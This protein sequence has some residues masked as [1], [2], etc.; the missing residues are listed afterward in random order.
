MVPALNR[1]IRLGGGL[2]C[3]LLVQLKGKSQETGNFIQN[4]S[5]TQIRAD[6]ANSATQN[7]GMVQADNGN[8]YIANYGD[9]LIFDGTWWKSAKHTKNLFTRALSKDREGKIYVAAQKDLGVL[10]VDSLGREEFVSLSPY[11]PSHIFEN[12]TCFDVIS[13]DGSIAYLLLNH[14]LV[15]NP[16]KKEMEVFESPAEIQTGLEQEGKLLLWLKGKGLFQLLDE[17][18]SPIHSLSSALPPS[19]LVKTILPI[20][21]GKFLL[22]S[23]DH[24]IFTYEAGEISAFG[25]GLLNSFPGLTIYHGTQL[26]DENIALATHEQGVLV[27]NPKGELLQQIDYRGG[28]QINTVIQVFQDQSGSIWAA[29]ESGVSRIRYPISLRA[30]GKE[31]GLEGIIFSVAKERE[32]LIA[33]TTTGLYIAQKN[34]PWETHLQFRKLPTIREAWDVLSYDG[35]IFIA[36]ATGI[37]ELTLPSTLRRISQNKIFR[38]LHPSSLHPDYIYVGSKTGLS[39]LKKEGSKWIYLPE[40]RELGHPINTLAESASGKLWAAGTKDAFRFSFGNNFPQI[41]EVLSLSPAMGKPNLQ[42][43]ELSEGKGNVLFGTDK[44]IYEFNDSNGEFLLKTSEYAHS[45]PDSAEIYGIYYSPQ[46]KLWFS[47]TPNLN[48]WI[49]MGADLPGEYVHL[50]YT[51]VKQYAWCFFTD[52]TKFTWIGTENGL[53]KVGSSMGQVPPFKFPTQIRA[54]KINEDSLLFGGDHPPNSSLDYSKGQKTYL[55]KLSSHIQEINFSFS[56][57]EY[58]SPEAL[59]YTY[60]LKGF[61]KSWS[62]WRKVSTK[63]YTGLWEGNYTFSVKARNSYGH[64]SE[65][66]SYSFRILPPWY[67]S[68]WAY[69]IYVALFLGFLALLIRAVTR[70]QQRKIL[71]QEQ[72]LK[73]ERETAERLRAVDRLKD[74]FLANTSHELRTPLNGIIGL[75][76]GLKEG[77]DREI[78]KEDEESLSLIISSGKRLASLV[79]DILDLSKMRNQDLQLTQKALDIYTLVDVV[80]RLNQPLTKGKAVALHNQVQQDLPPILA[81]ENR[82]QQVLQNLVDNAVKFTDRGTVEVTAHITDEPGFM[83]IQVVDTGIGIPKEKQEHI[84]GEFAQVD[85]SIQREYGGMGL[86]LSITRKLVELHGGTIG[87]DSQI[88]RGSTFQFTLPLAP[89]GFQNPVER[90]LSQTLEYSRNSPSPTQALSQIAPEVTYVHGNSDLFRILVVDDEVVNQH[91]LHNHLKGQRAEIVT[92][93]NGQEALEYIAKEHFD[94][95]LLDIMMPKMSGYE[96]CERIRAQYLPSE[97]PVIMVTAKN[98]VTDLVQGLELGANDYLAKPF[99]RSEFLA[100]VKTHLNLHQIHST[101]AKF[102]PT[103]FL[104]ALGYQAITEVVLGDHV[105]KEVSV[106]FA[107]IRDYTTLAETMNPTENFKFVNAF[108]KRMG[109]MIEQNRG[110]VNQYLGDCIMSIFPQKVED[111]LNAAINMQ[112]MLASYNGERSLK[113]RVPIRLGIGLH[114]GPLIF[115]IIGDERHLEAASIA[116]SVNTSARMESLSKHFGASIILSEKSLTKLQSPEQYNYRYLGQ[117]Q[118]KGKQEILGIYEFY[119]GDLPEHALAKYESQSLFE[120]GLT[121]FFR[122]EFLA[123]VKDFAEVLHKNPLDGPANY[124]LQKAQAYAENGVENDWSGVEMMGMK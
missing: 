37:Y 36:A 82:V 35:H 93:M 21:R 16:Q 57:P 86:G 41:E 28:L 123:A 122:K 26:D 109:P 124:F 92:A 107:D 108:T 7:W 112:H 95:I 31:S 68:S 89:A 6:G 106:M 120:K 15:W 81:D 1:I 4:W 34:K 117:V 54:V 49:P 46:D 65:A 77:T 23:K 97:L 115:G 114:T 71:A 113:S 87:V 80:L 45:L 72:E 91:V 40:E 8:M 105:E 64:E 75:A 90:S 84:F 101:T 104:K 48:G 44:G 99:S 83:E 94:L 11:L 63:S 47:T 67:R 14:I 98:Q 43:I 20:S 60:F 2:L 111:G 88:G 13:F 10:E 38:E 102:I 76:E 78:P 116:D 33:G 56:T 59:E 62:D 9:L 18:L 51:A 3:L 61:D 52:E 39:F 55:P 53:F 85:G 79:D 66:A 19:F 32:Y 121:K 69:L 74:E 58:T 29:L 30:W 12:Q 119:D 27:L 22:L 50:P 96:V 118:V 110:F 100:R 17:G 103:E 24:G 70:R 73:K 42:S 25:L 5:P